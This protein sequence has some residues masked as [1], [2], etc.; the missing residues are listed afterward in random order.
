MNSSTIRDRILNEVRSDIFEIVDVTI[1]ND[2]G[3]D[4]DEIDIEEFIRVTV[5]TETGSRDIGDAAITDQARMSKDVHRI[6]HDE[7]D[8]DPIR[9]TFR[10]NSPI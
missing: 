7:I 1:Q 3:L 6:V 2:A 8:H 5:Y 10:V 4:A 9:V